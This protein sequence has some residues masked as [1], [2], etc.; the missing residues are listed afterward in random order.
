MNIDSILK[1]RLNAE[2]SCELLKAENPAWRPLTSVY[3]SQQNWAQIVLGGHH[4]SC[5]GSAVTACG[6]MAMNS[7]STDLN[8]VQQLAK[9]VALKCRSIWPI[10]KDD[11][12]LGHGDSLQLAIVST[13]E[14]FHESIWTDLY[15]GEALALDSFCAAVGGDINEWLDDFGIIVCVDQTQ[16]ILTGIFEGTDWATLKEKRGRR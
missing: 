11:L 2:I 12:R 9:T 10:D 15:D 8:S 6:K 3:I 5:A 1:Y 7:T 16:R 13:L 14:S 4:G